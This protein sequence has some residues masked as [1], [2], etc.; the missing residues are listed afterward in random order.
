MIADDAPVQSFAGTLSIGEHSFDLDCTG[1][2]E[3]TEGVS[4]G[5]GEVA[6]D[7]GTF[8]VGAT[9][10]I[11]DLTAITHDAGEEVQMAGTA[12]PDWEKYEPNGEECGPVCWS[13]EATAIFI[14]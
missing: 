5:A 12:S 13:G 1:A 11:W 3:V 8:D 14:D 6:I 10:V 4:Y 9:D 2:A 7:V